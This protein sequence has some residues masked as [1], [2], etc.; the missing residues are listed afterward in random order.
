MTANEVYEILDR[1]GIDFDVIEIFEGFRVIHIN[2][3]EE[4]EENTNG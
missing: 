2:V 4:Q 3:D 1:E